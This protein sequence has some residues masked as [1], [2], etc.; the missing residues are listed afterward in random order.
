[1]EK[2]PLEKI[3]KLG[4]LF[5][6]KHNDFWQ[7]MDTKR[8]KEILEKKFKIIMNLNLFKDKKILITG[9]TGFKGSWLLLSYKTWRKKF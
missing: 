5:A 9:H 3:G 6:F 4:K 8:D 1:M 7:C 2:E